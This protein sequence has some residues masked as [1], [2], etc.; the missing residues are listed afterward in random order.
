MKPNTKNNRFLKANKLCWM[1]AILILCAVVSCRKY[2]YLGFTPGTGAPVITSV[3]TLTKTDTVNANDTI[4]AYNSSGDTTLTIRATQTTTSASDSVTTAGNL[5]NTYVI[6]GSNLGSATSVS[7]NGVP[8]YFNRALMTDNSIIVAVPST[9]PYLAPQATDSLKVTTLHGTAYF[10]FTIIPPPP[11]PTA[12][13]DYDFWDGSQITLK[14]VGFASVTGVGLTGS[15]ANVTIVSQTDTIMTLQ[16]PSTATSRSHLVFT[17]SSVGNT[18]TTVA[19]QE[20][21]D[22]D[23]TTNIVFNNNFQNAWVDAS[24]NGPSGITSGVAHG[25]GFTSSALGTYSANGWK[26]EG[27]ANWYPSTA[28]SNYTYLTFWV[29][30]GVQNET[31]YVVGD[32][33]PGGYGNAQ[34]NQKLYYPISVPAGVW[35]YFKIPL[36]SGAGQF[37]YWANG[38]VAQQLGFL[39]EPAS[40]YPSGSGQVDVLESIYFDEAAFVK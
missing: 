16:F 33:A 20:L 25:Y 1:A 4:V 18:V 37:N 23:N 19:T 26:I 30:G 14:G 29:R 39:L 36:G 2:N 7:F 38:A 10:K 15:S 34:A 3:H 35:S 28:D 27:W 17:Y 40:W 11:T 22:L 8:A 12:Y 13:T 6:E 31:L 5:G 32:Q 24:W 9:T 21:I